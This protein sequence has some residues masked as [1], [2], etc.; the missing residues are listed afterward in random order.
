MRQALVIYDTFTGHTRA[1]AELISARLEELD[2]SVKILRDKDFKGGMN[3]GG[4]DILAIGSPMHGGRVARTLF[5]KLAPLL[6]NDLSGKKLISFATSAGPNA[7]TGVCQEIDAWLKPTGITPVVS[8][9]CKGKP[10][11]RMAEILEL[12]IPENLL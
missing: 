1:L 10:G 2:F 8:I 6:Q 12:S 3:M 9:G 11:E 5:K 7:Y 4:V